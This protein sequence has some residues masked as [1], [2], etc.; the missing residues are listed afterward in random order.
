[1]FN[2]FGNIL[3][4]NI[5]GGRLLTIYI[6]I[7]FCLNLIIDYI[8]LLSVK[9]FLSLGAKPLR[10]LLG[11]TI[12]GISSFVILL[13]PMPSGVSWLISFLSA[14]IIVAATFYPVSR[15]KFLKT[16]AAFFLISFCYCG[17]MIAIWIIFS[18]QNIVIRNS[19]VYIGISPIVLIIT[20][21]LC[22]IILRVILRITGR[23]TAKNLKCKVKIEYNEIIKEFDGTID[24]GNTLKEPFSGECVIVAR[25]EIFKD[26]FDADEYMKMTADNKSTLKCN[27]RLIPFNSVGGVGLIPA[28]KPNFIKITADSEETE[29]SAYL[30]LCSGKNLTDDVQSLVPV[31]LIMKGS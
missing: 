19:S 30:A 24:T 3:C 5:F 18:P 26:I 14:C 7:L 31:E 6:D 17:A 20:T 4:I 13:P 29:V 23:G 8:I 10:L 9:L 2:L 28:I 21:L 16:A 15:I 22:Y 11:A 25:A 27:V 12:G 1:M